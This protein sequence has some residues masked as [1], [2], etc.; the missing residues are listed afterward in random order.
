MSSTPLSNIEE[1]AERSL[2]QR[3]L[4]ECVDKG[5]TPNLQNTSTYPDTP[6]GFA[7]LEAA[8]TNIKTVKGF[9]IEIFNY[10]KGQAKNYKKVPRIVINTQNT[11]P[12]ALGG[13]LDRHYTKNAGT[14]YASVL[15]PQTSDLYVDIH[16]ISDNVLQHRVLN[17]ILALAIPRRGFIP[18]YDDPTTNLFVRYISYLEIQ[19]KETGL[20][21]KVYRYE[22]PDIFE[23]DG[24]V[25]ATGISPLKTMTVTPAVSVATPKP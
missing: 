1:V 3:L 25:V 11:L 22:I 5:Y 15:P 14:Y 21:E 19:D 13:D 17:A 4:T 18:M 10:S 20:I 7:A 24:H 6:A 9:S 23:T 8:Y 12:G 16:L 2:Y